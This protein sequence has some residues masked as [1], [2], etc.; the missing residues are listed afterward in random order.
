MDL[1]ME[2]DSGPLTRLFPR[3]ISRIRLRSQPGVL[4]T[5]ALPKATPHQLNNFPAWLLITASRCSFQHGVSPIAAFP[6]GGEAIGFSRG[7]FE[8]PL[9]LEAKAHLFGLGQGII[10][11][12]FPLSFSSRTGE[13]GRDGSKLCLLCGSSKQL[14]VPRAEILKKQGFFFLPGSSLQKP[15]KP[16]TASCRCFKT[17]Q[18]PAGEQGKGLKGKAGWGPQQPGAR[19]GPGVTSGKQV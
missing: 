16:K 14:V 1:P 15:L 9:V 11:Y 12:I 2:Q 3:R 17:S 19:T 5:A 18:L 8:H 7:I 10:N 13:R 4:Q 6:G